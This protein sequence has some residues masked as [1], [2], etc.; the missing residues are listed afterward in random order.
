M[1][2]NA[3]PTTYEEEAKNEEWHQAMLE[4]LVTART[5][6][7]KRKS[8]EEQNTYIFTKAF[9]QGKFDKF[10]SA[11]GVGNFESRGSVK[12]D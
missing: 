10:R 1:L 11:I 12:N 4:E 8:C 3:D 7:L 2:Q 5:V 9:P 6:K